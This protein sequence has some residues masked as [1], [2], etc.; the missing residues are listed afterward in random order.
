MDKNPLM[1]K[2]I[3]D[4]LELMYNETNSSLLEVFVMK[5][6]I[7]MVLLI[8]IVAFS[9]L[10][11]FAEGDRPDLKKEVL[12]EYNKID[13]E[14]GYSTFYKHANPDS[15]TF[16]DDLKAFCKRIETY[17][18]RHGFANPL[19]FDPVLNKFNTD[20]YQSISFW[21]T[22]GN[23]SGGNNMVAK[24]FRHGD[25]VIST[26]HGTHLQ[27]TTQHCGLFDSSEFKG[28]DDKERNLAQCFHTAEPDKGVCYESEAQ[29]RRNYDKTWQVVVKHSTYG[30]R[31]NAVYKARQD[32]R[33]GMPYEWYSAK[34]DTT[35][36]YCSKIAWYGYKKGANIDLNSVSY[37]YYENSNYWCTP[38]DIIDSWATSIWNKW[39]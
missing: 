29:F 30:E 21:E 24:M 2:F 39:D 32:A 8:I 33:V 6:Y 14:I 25:I 4:T 34:T 22:Q 37:K 38:D 7:S 20:E 3:D 23:G 10:K 13:A 18:I 28:K 5:G 16:Q 26:N 1:E 36:W 9:S 17:K 15:P 31:Y 11:C 27:G 19:T 35:K 12:D